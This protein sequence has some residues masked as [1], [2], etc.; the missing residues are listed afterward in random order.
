MEYAIQLSFDGKTRCRDMG[1]I[2]Y[3]ECVVDYDEAIPALLNRPCEVLGVVTNPLPVMGS[4][5]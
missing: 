1:T 3:L 2:L 4:R 5:R